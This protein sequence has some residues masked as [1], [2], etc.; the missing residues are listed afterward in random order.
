M[1]LGT[2]P[3]PY[4]P[5]KMRNSNLLKGTCSYDLYHEGALRNSWAWGIQPALVG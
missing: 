2:I 1:L 5:N 4:L 3:K